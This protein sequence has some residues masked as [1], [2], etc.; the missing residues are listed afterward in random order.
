VLR[1]TLCAVAQLA[2]MWG[3]AG[4]CCTVVAEI[5]PRGFHRGQ[6]VLLPAAASAELHTAEVTMVASS[7]QQLRSTTAKHVLL[8][9]LLASA[10]CQHHCDTFV[11]AATVAGD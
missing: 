5:G 9:S 1:E 8:T 6:P 2:S 7:M 3:L 10:C 4:A 11:R